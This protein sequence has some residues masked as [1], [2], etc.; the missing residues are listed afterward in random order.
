MKSL[1]AYNPGSGG[2]HVDDILKRLGNVET[3]VSELKSKVSA[4]LATV[5]HL[6]TKADVLDVRSAVAE[7]R[8]EMVAGLGSLKAEMTAESG[9]VRAEMAAGLGSLKAEMTAESGA[10]RAE[11]A[12]GLGALRTEMAAESGAMRAEM[13]AESGAMRA[14]MA[15]GLGSLRTEMAAQS[16]SLRVEMGSLRAEMA[17][18]ETAFIKWM[19]ATVLA[20]SG[21]A[22]TVAKFVH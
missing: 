11:M 17:A 16:G 6:A 12:A 18:H 1:V 10:V 5:P 4:I 7:L 19:I 8:T 3:D 20:T 9:A 2:G 15:A 22:F 14:E 13:A 21:L